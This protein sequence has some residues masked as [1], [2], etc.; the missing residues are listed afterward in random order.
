M[1]VTFSDPFQQRVFN[2]LEANE[3]GAAKANN[4][5]YVL[6]PPLSGCGYTWGHLQSSSYIDAAGNVD[7]TR[8]WGTASDFLAGNVPG[9]VGVN[10]VSG[11]L[12]IFQAISL[13]EGANAQ[14]LR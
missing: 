8:V 13:D 1:T 4:V 6:S 5:P 3:V 10:L 12:Q 7:W 14:R 9:A 11:A 2:V